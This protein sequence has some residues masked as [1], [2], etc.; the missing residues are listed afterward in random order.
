MELLPVLPVKPATILVVLLRKVRWSM[1][2][3]VNIPSKKIMVITILSLRPANSQIV[4]NRVTILLIILVS[5]YYIQLMKA[6]S[7]I[8]ALFLFLS[9]I[10]CGQANDP[11]TASP[12][13]STDDSIRNAMMLQKKQLAADMA[14]AHIEYFVI[15]VP[16]NQ[17]GYYIMID[18]KMY[19]EQ[20]SIPAVQGNNGFATKDDA[21]KIAK[22]AIE[23]IRQGEMPPTIS[24]D[25]LKELGVISNQ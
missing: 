13:I 22:L 9:T 4:I 6:I 16:E 23:K 2:Q 25:E 8:T 1:A 18:G 14:K 21:E 17:F 10:G 20:K 11:K 12:P 7:F 24:V 5:Y 3:V 19:I 15:N